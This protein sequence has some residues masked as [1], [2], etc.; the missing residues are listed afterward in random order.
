MNM[1]R[2]P[3]E[4]L[5]EIINE[6]GKGLSAQDVIRQY[7]GTSEKYLNHLGMP[8]LESSNE[9]KNSTSARLLSENRKLRQIINDLN[10]ENRILRWMITKMLSP[11]QQ[12]N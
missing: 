6:M 8:V 10:L 5:I 4:V 3:D 12:K 11:N 2:I 9:T 1:L 7:G